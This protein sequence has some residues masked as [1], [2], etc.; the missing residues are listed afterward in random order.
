MKQ[1][2]FV[3]FTTVALLMLA[4]GAAPAVDGALT[5]ARASVPVSAGPTAT[6]ARSASTSRTYDAVFGPSRLD[7]AVECSKRAFQASGSADT[8]VLATGYDWPDAVGGSALAGAYGCPLLLT[9][10]SPLS[11]QVIDEARRLNVS[12]VVILG[13]NRAIS[14]AV[15]AALTALDVNGHGLE[16][17]RVGGTDR[18]ET[19]ARIA[20]A[21]VDVLTSKGG[22]YDGV[23]FFATGQN[24]PDALAAA[25]I[26]AAERWPILLVKPTGLSSPTAD[27][28]ASLDVTRGIILGSASAV[29]T[30]V[31][32]ALTAALPAPPSASS[33]R[34]ATGRRSRSRTSGSRTACRGTASPWR[35]GRTSPMRSP[36]A[37]WPARSV[38]SC[39]SRREPRSTR[40][41]PPS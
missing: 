33:A 4:T 21:T 9:S 3:L 32:D 34:R 13:S 24:F 40:V 19:A 10:P 30:A 29:T 2:R 26:A 16:V 31:A 11:Q 1:H 27:A 36:A 8:I 25:P 28:I 14:D 6:P 37:S 41:C 15:E 5:S 7:T 39:C 35:P 38:R 18:F 23:A 20:S 17:L 22:T 12:R